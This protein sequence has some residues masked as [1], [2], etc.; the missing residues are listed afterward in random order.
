MSRWC[1]LLFLVAALVAQR[2]TGELRLSVVDSTGVGIEVAG[3]LL[4]QAIQ[5]NQAF[6]TTNLTTRNQRLD[7]ALTELTGA[8]SDMIQVNVTAFQF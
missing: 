8:M 5:L 7:Q 3:S 6:N 2:R 1:V 4:S